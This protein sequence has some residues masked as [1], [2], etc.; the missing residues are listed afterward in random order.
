MLIKE[1]AGVVAV[2]LAIVAL[3]AT[4]SSGAVAQAQN[5]SEKSQRV[6]VTGSHIKRSQK[7]GSSPIQVIS[8]TEI[9]DS[10]AKTVNELLQQLTTNGSDGFRDTASQNG[11]S[12]GVA[13]ASL[14]NLGS[15][16]TL[17]LLN[18]R[19]ITPSAYANPNNGTSTLYDL[20]TIPISALERV[21]IFKDGASAVYGSDAIA[22]VINFI[23]KTNY[24]GGEIAVRAGA[25]DDNNFGKR[26]VSG[27][28]GFGD[29]DKDRYNVFLTLDYNKTDPTSEREGS[30]DIQAEK[31]AALNFRLNPFNSSISNQPFFY[32]ERKPGSR[33]FVTGKTVVNRTGCDPSR[34]LVGGPQYNITAGTLLGR[35]FCNFDTDQFFDV[36]GKGQDISTLGRGTLKISETFSAFTEIAVTKSDRDYRA[37]PRAFNA[38]GGPTTNFLVGGLATPFQAILPIGHPDNPFP[39]VRAAAAY[40]FENLRGG[41]HLTNESYRILAGLKG[42]VGQWDW[43][44]AVLWNRSNRDEVTYGL[45]YLPTLRTLLTENRS[46]A[47]LAADPT[48]S[49]DPRNKGFAQVLQYDAKATTDFGNLPGGAIGFASGVEFREEKIGLTPDPA[50]ARGDILGLANTEISGKRNVTSAFVEFRTPWLKNFE[51]DFA[52]R[53]DKY[54][55][56]KTNFVPKVGGKWTVNDAFSL[57]G[58][59]AKGFRAPAVSQVSPGG[60]QFFL[61]GITDPVRC[62][63]GTTPAPGA[64]QIDCAK[65]I[66]GVGG[67]NPDLKPETSKS[68]SLGAIYS[69]TSTF[70]VLLD[71]YKIRKEGEVALGSADT[72]LLHPADYPADAILRDTN[73][74]NQLVDAS[75]K[76][77]PNSGPLLAVKTPWTNQG[78]TEVRGLDLEVR[79]RNSL[80]SFGNL[81]STL[82]AAYTLSYKRAEAPG[83]VE[84]NVAGSNGGLSDFATSAGDIPRLKATLSTAWTQGP[85]KVTALA[86]FVSSISLLRRSENAVV[87]PEAYCHFGSGQPATA[88]SLGGVP[89]YLEYYPDCKVPSWTTLDMGYDYTGFK[90]MTIGVSVANILD[91][92][93][94]YYP[95]G[96]TSSLV[97]NGYN[98]G[99]HNDLGR[100]ITLRAVYKFD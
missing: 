63:N 2:R 21:E 92:K 20:N 74:A 23:T 47:S 71:Y 60:A 33:S 98:T 19:R 44:T 66:S 38:Q 25:N 76:P 7:E 95:A 81:S 40:R 78:S 48:I 65:N 72:V 70:D 45:L 26:G 54:P 9:H 97:A 91:K 75:G 10:G 56:I 89:G 79:M 93:A 80:G 83:D 16:S 14:R 3:A 94:P 27:I 100:Y 29:L 41:S 1:K 55:G 62:P 53:L 88:Y 4:V 59:Y 69:P 30:D 96:N 86:H 50:N 31:Y 37:A 24:Q 52:G 64:D 6:E 84:A 34:L 99:L 46:L 36:Q 68:F 13:T 87:Y 67:A 58:T 18:G 35:T 15:T 28:V 32:R 49:Y 61:N 5:A 73:P 12:R 43:E 57:R 39:D 51:M 82:R 90:N 22:G 17:I 77:I 11:F 8:V 42:T 85:H